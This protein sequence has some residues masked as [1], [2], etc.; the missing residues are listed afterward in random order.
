MQLSLKYM[1]QFY[2]TLFGPSILVI[3]FGISKN[4]RNDV[5]ILIELILEPFTVWFLYSVPVLN[6]VHL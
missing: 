1:L 2:N 5:V 3:Y 6:I 4:F